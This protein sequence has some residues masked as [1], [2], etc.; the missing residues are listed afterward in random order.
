MNSATGQTSGNL[1]GWTGIGDAAP[2][3]RREYCNRYPWACGS[4][5]NGHDDDETPGHDYIL[6]NPVCLNLSW[7]NCTEDEVATYMTHFQYP[8]QQPWH[9]VVDSY[10]YDV[11][12]AE[13]WGIPN[14][15]LCFSGMCDS[16]AIRVEFGDDP[17][18][19]VNVTTSTH[20]FNVGD[21]ERQ[22]ELGADGIWY[23]T[24]HGTGTNDGFG[25]IPGAALDYVNQK[26]GPIVFNGVD[27]Q[28]LAYTTTIETLQ[29]VSTFMP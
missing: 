1:S 9:S 3:N 22:S 21:V 28:L 20:I 29:H 5:Q 15:L 24:T 12:P 10:Y 8:G 25:V 17:L 23:V 2:L 4:N 18:T 14:P 26:L 13:F 6:T 27:W 11:W 19:I 7:I 16:G